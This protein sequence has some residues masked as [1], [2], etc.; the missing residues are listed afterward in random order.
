MNE[1]NANKVFKALNTLR[2]SEPTGLISIHATY[3]ISPSGF[4]VT[5]R[6]KLLTE[7]FEVETIKEAMDCVK[8]ARTEAGQKYF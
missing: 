4:T 3:A 6:H 1:A 2:S 7:T 5:I 8:L